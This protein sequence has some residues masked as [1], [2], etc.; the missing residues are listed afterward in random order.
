MKKT[1]IKPE[2]NVIK[3]VLGQDIA[4][5]ITVGSAFTGTASDIQSKDRGTRNDADDFDDLW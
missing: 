3:T 2:T 5:G 4:T 1:Y